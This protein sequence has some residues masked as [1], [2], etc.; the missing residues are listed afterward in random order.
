[1]VQ[2][3][4][5]SVCLREGRPVWMPLFSLCLFSC[6]LSKTWTVSLCSNSALSASSFPLVDIKGLFVTVFSV[7]SCLCLPTFSIQ[8]FWESFI[9]FCVFI[10]ELK[11][12]RQERAGEKRRWWAEGHRPDVTSISS[13]SPSSL[14]ADRSCSLRFSLVLSLHTRLRTW[15]VLCVADAPCGMTV[16]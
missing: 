8:V 9:A 12:R 7:F 1:M 10:G 6:F 5:K 3:L 4:C 15:L 14:C 11:W 2:Q 13:L 16:E